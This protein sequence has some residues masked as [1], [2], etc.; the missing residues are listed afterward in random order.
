MEEEV[1]RLGGS[2][3]LNTFDEQF[4]RAF[5]RSQA[6]AFSVMIKKRHAKKMEK[7]SAALN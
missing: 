4:A 5:F 6:E 3:N 1:E 2:K 7:N